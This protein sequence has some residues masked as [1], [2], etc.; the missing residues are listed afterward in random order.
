MTDPVGDGGR[1]GEVWAVPADTT[2]RAANIMES[3]IFFLVWVAMRT[4]G[5]Y[6]VRSKPA[7]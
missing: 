2:L 5:V 3:F 6:E 7:E 1:V 4:L